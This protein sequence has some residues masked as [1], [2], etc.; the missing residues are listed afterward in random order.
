[1]MLQMLM[2]SGGRGAVTLSGGTITGTDSQVYVQIESNGTI[3]NQSGAYQS[4]FTPTTVGVGSSYWVRFTKQSGSA[5]TLTS[6][7]GWE[8]LAS[9]CY[10]GYDVTASGVVRVEIASD[11]GGSTILATGDYTITKS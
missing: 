3:T 7:S 6:G 8:S 10:W 11:S 9:A 4:W 1:M 5:A 2:G